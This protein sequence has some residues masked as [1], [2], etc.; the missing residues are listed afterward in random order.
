MVEVSDS[1]LW[2]SDSTTI[3]VN[4][5]APSITEFGPFSGDEPFLASITTDATDPGSDDLTFTWEF[6][7]GPTFITTY[8]NDG[9]GPDPADSYLSGVYPF[10]AVD[11]ASHEY[12]D[13]G[14]YSV[15][16]TVE[17]D[18]GGSTEYTTYIVVFNVAPTIEEVEAYILVNFT[19][20]AA[21]EKWHNVQMHV[22][23]DGGDIA[24]AEVT[25]YPGSPDDQSVTLYSVK[26][27]VT[28]VIEVKVY[29]TPW[30]DPP[31]GQ[32]NGATPVWVTLDFEDGEDN[33][34]HHTCNVM[35]PDTWEWIIGMNQYFVG[36]NI[37]F[38]GTASDPGSDDLTF[39]WD[40]DDGTAD[41]VTIY[42]NDGMAPDP[43]PSPDGIYP[44][45]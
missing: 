10:T 22:Q 4:N 21:G 32:P 14:N 6:S 44:Q 3:E 29:Y 13:N 20:R 7:M 1:V 43:Y 31:N 30:D 25:R 9:M 16:L 45:C 17:D 11:S 38:E 23:E 39:S 41:T 8:Y 2:D 35:H 26:C 27:D 5:V 37:T 40:W 12:G 33:L 36:H 18:N 34:L 42:Y 15:T 28:K 19:L 24:F